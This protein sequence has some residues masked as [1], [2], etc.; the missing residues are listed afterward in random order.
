MTAFIVP[1]LLTVTCLCR[2]IGFSKS[3]AEITSVAMPP[4]I[5]IDCTTINHDRGCS[6]VLPPV[7]SSCEVEVAAGVDSAVELNVHHVLSG[8]VGAG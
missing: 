2:T 6:N 4:P 3:S 7:A 1:S 5:A 8:I